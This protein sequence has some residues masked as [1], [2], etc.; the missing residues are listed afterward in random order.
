MYRRATATMLLTYL[1]WASFGSLFAGE[2]VHADGNGPL[3]HRHELHW[4]HAVDSDVVSHDQR[5][6]GES[7]FENYASGPEFVA[8]PHLAEP[9]LAH[10]GCAPVKIR[11]YL[12]AVP[13][14]VAIGWNW[15]NYNLSKPPTAYSSRIR[16]GT[17]RPRT[18]ISS[19]CQ[20]PRP[21]PS[22]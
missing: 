12:L 2:H 20:L 7:Q 15:S 22:L 6:S 21:P 1:A 10:I 11:G 4:H 8:P 5:N 17:D 13:A 19:H 3:V 16:D 9:L 14:F 18:L